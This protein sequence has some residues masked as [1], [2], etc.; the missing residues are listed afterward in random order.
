ML[1]CA[2]ERLHTEPILAPPT[3]VPEIVRTETMTL[4]L[5]GQQFQNVLKVAEITFLPRL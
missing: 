5:Y 1:C 2:A 4:H 3:C